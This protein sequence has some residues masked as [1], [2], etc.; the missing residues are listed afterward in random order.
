MQDILNNDVYNNHNIKTWL[1]TNLS[2]PGF[3][4]GLAM[5]MWIC[6]NQSNFVKY[7]FEIRP[8][9]LNLYLSPLILQLQHFTIHLFYLLIKL[10]WIFIVYLCS[11]V[12][13]NFNIANNI[14]FLEGLWFRSGT[15]LRF[16]K[17]QSLKTVIII[18]LPFIDF[19]FIIWK[20]YFDMQ[21]FLGFEQLRWRPIFFELFLLV[22]LYTQCL[23]F[24][25]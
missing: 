3:L 7:C 25:E 16:Q 24:S 14:Y 15:K 21:S 6:W 19:Y 23:M 4:A 13:R 17:C 10:L 1:S 8:K 22:S 11:S 20:K 2:G 5:Y 9:T 18:F 12:L